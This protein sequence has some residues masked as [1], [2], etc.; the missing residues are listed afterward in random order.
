MS[1]DPGL[2]ELKQKIECYFGL[3]SQ[4]VQDHKLT[5]LILYSPSGVPLYDIRISHYEKSVFGESRWAV[6][7]MVHMLNPDSPVWHMEVV[8]KKE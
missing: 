6:G 7:G 4:I 5:R 1:E 8:D 3:T 2:L